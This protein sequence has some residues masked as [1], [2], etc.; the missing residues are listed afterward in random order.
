MNLSKFLFKQ[1]LFVYSFVMLKKNLVQTS[2]CFIML[3]GL[4]SRIFLFNE[5]GNI[6]NSPI[7]VPPPKK[8]PPFL[9]P[10]LLGFWTFSAISQPKG[11][12]VLSLMIAPL[13]SFLRAR[14]THLQLYN[15]SPVFSIFIQAE[16]VLC[17]VWY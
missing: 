8:A 11:A 4:F 12:N 9:T 6:V 13:R 15:T 7:K 1:C 17:S 3:I 16:H 2:S 5:G 10:S 14:S